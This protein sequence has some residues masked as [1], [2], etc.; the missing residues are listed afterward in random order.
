[1]Q[2]KLLATVVASLVV[3]QAMAVE[4]F[5]DGT[6]SVSIGGRIGLVVNKE[7][8]EEV[9]AKNDS[10]RINFKFAHK[11]SDDLTAHAVAEWGFNALNN[12]TDN[13]EGD[14]DVSTT[15]DDTFWS[16]LGFVGLEHSSLGTVTAGKN[17]SVTYDVTGWTEAYAIG[18]GGGMAVYDRGEF[19]GTSRADDVIQYRN[20]FGGLNIGVQTQLS[21]REENS[22]GEGATRNHSYGFAVSYDLPIGLSAGATYNEAELDNKANPRSAT[23]A[24]KF[25]NERIYLAA[26]YGQ[27]RNKTNVTGGTIN[28][29]NADQESE[30]IELYAKHQLPQ[31]V[32][33]FA[34]H[35]GY[36]E[37]SVQRDNAGNES[38]ARFEEFM[39]GAVY[40]TGP[41]QFAFEWSNPKTKGHDGETTDSGQAYEF[42][43]RYYF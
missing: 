36:N 10:A 28:S 40:N 32:Q 43:A 22:T 27:F 20:S 29:A 31:I 42:Q 23:G 7:H 21:G 18:G 35:A 37:L 8:S 15:K 24:I 13:D 30:G 9:I 5:N 2:K 16:R 11:L 12:Y 6:S 3:G 39:L 41:M 19:D 38:K 4:V 34:L 25:V 17:W 26:S 1:M 14:G 33:G